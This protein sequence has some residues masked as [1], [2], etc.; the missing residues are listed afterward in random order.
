MTPGMIELGSEQFS[1]NQ[2]FAAHA[3]KVANDLIIVGRTNA[4]A[5][6]EGAHQ[7]TAS[8]VSVATRSDAVEWVRAHLKARDTVLYENDF[9]DHYP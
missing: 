8:V 7:G 9:P 3:A 4:R 1:A 6:A 5:L 2:E